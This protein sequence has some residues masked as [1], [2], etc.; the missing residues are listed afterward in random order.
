MVNLDRSVLAVSVTDVNRETFKLLDSIR[1]N[2]ISF[3]QYLG[4]ASK[5]YYE[6][7]CVGMYKITDFAEDTIATP[8]FFSDVDIWKKYIEKCPKNKIKD[9]QKRHQQIGNILNKRVEKILNE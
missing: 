4:L 8:Q 6:N 2:N 3:A 9:L 5:E 7:H 1:P